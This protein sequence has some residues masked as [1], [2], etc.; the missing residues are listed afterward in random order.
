MT[1]SGTVTNENVL[2]TPICGFIFIKCLLGFPVA[3]VVE[4]PP[5]NTGDMDPIPGSERSPGEGNNHSSILAWESPWTEEPGGLQSMG[6]QRIRH[7]RETEC[8][9]L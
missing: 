1:C 3:S 5:A 9:E 6:S 7:D 4:N 8:P 2:Q